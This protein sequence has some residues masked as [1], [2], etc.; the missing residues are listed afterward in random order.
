MEITGILKQKVGEQAGQSER[1]N[2]KIAQFLLETI[3]MYPKRVCFEVSD[4][5]SGRIAQWE[6]LVGKDVKV[7]FDINAREY[8][9][10]WFNSIRGYGIEEQTVQPR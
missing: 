5:L 9:G 4:G 1:G 6:G 10:K 2:W 3:D 7:K 8:Q